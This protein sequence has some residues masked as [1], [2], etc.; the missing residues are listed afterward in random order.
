MAQ[1][2]TV[3]IVVEAVGDATLK[4]ITNSLASMNRALKDTSGTLS[5][6]KSLALGLGGVSIFGFGARELMDIADGMIQTQSRIQAFTG[7]IDKTNNI[8]RQLVI[9]ANE[10]KSSINDTKEVFSRILTA[11]NR[12]NISTESQI[13]L[14]RILQ[15]S[16]RLSG[17]TTSEATAS[18][19]Q[20]AQALSF[21]QL[22]GQELRSVL[23]Q[24]SVLANI[25]AK[26]IEGSGKDI[27]KFAEAGG[28][29]TKFVLKA[30]SENF[31][32]IEGQAGTL[33][34]TFGQT[35]TLAMNQFAV[36]IDDVNKRFDLNGKFA[37]GL[38]VIIGN[39]ET[40]TQIAIVLATS[41]LPALIA[42]IVGV[43]AALNP[44]TLAIMAI[45]TAS[46]LVY[47]NWQKLLLSAQ[48]IGMMGKIVFFDLADKIANVGLKLFKAFGRDA[49]AA[50]GI[51][52]KEVSL[53]L[54]SAITDM[55]ALQKQIAEGLK[56]KDADSGPAKIMNDTSDGAKAL[57]DAAN[58]LADKAKTLKE[59][60]GILNTEFNKGKLSVEV[61]NQELL[62]LNSLMLSEDLKEGSISLKE[63]DKKIREVEIQ[64]LAREI[65]YG[66]ISL[67]YFQEVS[68]RFSAQKL[69]TEFNEGK[70]SAEKLNSELAKLQGTLNLLDESNYL[71]G[72][73]AGLTKTLNDIGNV[74]TAISEV[75]TNAFKNLEDNMVMM[76]S[77][78]KYDF[79]QFVNSILADLTRMVVR[80]AVIAPIARG[81]LD[82]M[83][84]GAGVGFS[85][86]GASPNAFQA[87]GGA[88]NDGVQFFA[89][90]GIV[91]SPTLFGHSQGLG[92]MGEAGPE[93]ILPLKRSSD[94]SLGV[95]A[96]A[97]TINV[98][99]N[100]NSEVTTSETTTADGGRIIE[101]MIVGKVREGIANG[102]FDQ[103]LKQSFG[104][105][106]KGI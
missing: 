104:L 83:T 58:K 42:K 50:L 10:T 37:K 8:L 48:E 87:K 106:R 31:N 17:S 96:A 27:Y 90:G 40:L 47:N 99:N 64:N 67:E 57:A 14:S 51:F 80:M 34:Q 24:N 32:R 20:F 9:Q 68:N 44:W 23:S 45:S 43:V 73:N 66:R 61:F 38:D 95:G 65:E 105:Q 91:N 29:T 53:S 101:V 25:F 81:F 6:M 2:R 59:Q 76:I 62:R 97:V 15:Q 75:T 26:A 16:F 93:A 11:T 84:G 22:R 85:F 7:D 92:V 100:S 46:I 3:K 72:F 98:I 74:A 36:K 71:L 41:A 13:A 69:V 86:S 70:I 60:I 28:F 5:S 103:S 19:I 88:W 56:I 39:L 102:S 54:K 82:M 49:P 4:R 94:G 12:L 63:F 89:N 79:S 77:E 18:T 52:K 21:G 35:L 33:A 30:L 1:T 55:D 78:S